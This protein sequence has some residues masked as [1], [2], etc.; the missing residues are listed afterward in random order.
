MRLKRQLNL[1]WKLIPD[2]NG[3]FPRKMRNFIFKEKFKKKNENRARRQ[4]AKL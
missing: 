1:C 3:Q 2:D 4:I